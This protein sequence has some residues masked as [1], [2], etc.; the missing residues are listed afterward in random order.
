M[1]SRIAAMVEDSARVEGSGSDDA[2]EGSSSSSS[3]D[4]ATPSTSTA[5]MVSLDSLCCVVF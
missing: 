1:K 3:E 4:E 2:E 5:R